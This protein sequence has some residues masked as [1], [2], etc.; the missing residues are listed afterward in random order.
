MPEPDRP[1]AYRLKHA[2][3]ERWRFEGLS[4]S[5]LK[6]TH[7]HKFAEGSEEWECSSCSKKGHTLTCCPL[8]P[9]PVDIKHDTFAPKLFAVPP[10]VIKDGSPLLSAITQIKSFVASFG[11]TNPFRSESSSLFAL[12]KNAAAWRAIG[13]PVSVLSWV[14][15]GYKL[16]FLKEPPQIGFENHPGAFKHAEFIDH[17]IERR[18]QKG[19]MSEINEKEAH[20]INPMDVVPKASG[21]FRLI[22]DCR[23]PNAFLPDVFFR[24]ENLSVVPSVVRQGDFLFST[25]LSDAYYHI[26]IHESSRKFLCVRWRGK[27]Y[28]YN[29]LPFGL[30]LA[31]WLF[32]KTL[33]SVIKFC[34]RL[35]IAVIAYLDDFLWADDETHIHTLVQFARE[36][37]KLLGFEVSDTKSE[38]HPTELLKFLGLLIDAREYAFI[39]PPEKIEK[40]KSLITDINRCVQNK[41]KVSARDIARVCGHLLSIRLAVPPARIFTR[42]LYEVLNKSSAWN[43]RVELSANAIDELKFWMD[44]L[45][46]FR[47]KALIR[48]Q[49]AYHLFT[50]ASEDGWGAHVDRESA[51]GMFEEKERSPHTSSTYRELKA[52]LS[53]LHSPNIVSYV[54]DS[55]VTFTLDSTAAVANLNK[56]GGPVPELSSLVK[57]IWQECIKHNIDATAEWLRRDKNEEADALSRYRDRADWQLNP[58]IFAWIDKIFGPHTIDRF[59]STDNTK[60]KRFNARY[61]DAEAEAIDAFTQDWSGEANYANPDWNDIAKVIEHARKYRARLTLIYPDWPSKPWYRTIQRDAKRIVVLPASPDTLIPGARSANISFITAPPFLIRAALFDFREAAH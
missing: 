57:E 3:D 51:F 5:A 42:A 55:R 56:G 14:Y 48:D 11:D 9:T 31:P 30:N 4:L 33:R 25:D 58:S 61:F 17:E 40:I 34:R 38:W 59:A 39:V 23:L 46:L 13:T 47:A 24:L 12:R 19:Q 15:A 35:G 45:H 18:V 26:P 7:P 16:R 27:V 52:L 29:V 49:S 2:T 8:S 44:S 6:R 53:A 37:L 50:D 21:S 41:L 22:V 20:I 36:I 54:R 43:Q 60:L 1:R 28:R 32:T 10:P